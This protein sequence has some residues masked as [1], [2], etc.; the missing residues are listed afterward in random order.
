MAQ[1][2]MPDTP[3]MKSWIEA[4]HAYTPGRSTGEGGRPL[5]KLSANEN[6]FGC[7]P[8][9]L[10][11][12]RDADT[13]ARYPDPDA[14][15]LREAIGAKHGIDP[16]RIVCGAG[17]GEM[18]QC[19]VQAFAGPGD[20]VLFAEY[21]FSLYPL[22]AMKVGAEPVGARMADYVAS[23]D[24]LLAAV[25]ERTRVVLLDN[26][27][28]PCG[29]WIDA[30]EIK[31]L[32]DGLPR[33]VLLVV[34]QAY[35]EYLGAGLDDGALALASR[36]PNVL[37]TRTFS[38]AYGLASERIGWATGAPDLVGA[39]NRLRGAFNVSSAGQRAAIAGLADEGF[40]SASQTQNAAARTAFAAAIDAMG[41]HGIRAVP[42]EANFV[43]VLFEGALTADDAMA[44]IEVGGYAVRHLPGQG[45][46]HA[47]RITIGTRAQMDEIAEILRQAARAAA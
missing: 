18:L 22:L 10:A 2:A 41:N 27:N 3:Q 14:T 43:L 6:P 7:S 1:F 19:A 13:L 37:V 24:A 46:P 4:I 11:A 15:A 16:A 30:R 5:I 25:T 26:P 31:R 12:L 17:S 8:D 21:S 28:N 44:A 33:D 40:L 23:V 29:S 47:L 42:S 34:D 32:H 9:A 39:I 35:A 38:K 20:E 36:H 45:L